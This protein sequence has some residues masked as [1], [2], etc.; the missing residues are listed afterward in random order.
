MIRRGFSG[1]GCE[2]RRVSYHLVMRRRD[3][4]KKSKGIRDGH[5]WG[6]RTSSWKI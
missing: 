4:F 1:K 3:K 2:E 6:I 5:F